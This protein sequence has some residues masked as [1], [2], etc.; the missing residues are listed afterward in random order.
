MRTIFS[1]LLATLLIYP[2]FVSAKDY[3]F[4]GTEDQSYENEENWYPEFP[5]KK[6][7]LG[8]R[9]IIQADMNFERTNLLVEGELNVEL[10]AMLHSGSGSVIIKPFGALSNHGSISVYGVINYG[11]FENNVAAMVVIERYLAHESATTNN[12]MSA[13]F[14]TAHH[15]INKGVF[16]NY[17]YCEVGG[18]FKNTSVFN[19]INNSELDVSGIMIEM[20]GARLNQSA[21]SVARIGDAET[22]E[23]R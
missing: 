2:S 1:I 4:L 23:N 8:D 11:K 16:N 18:N 19:Q 12:L 5:G 15:I 9:V 22:L 7:R 13:R 21:E 17:S 3:F 6:I 10:G 14:I 20:P